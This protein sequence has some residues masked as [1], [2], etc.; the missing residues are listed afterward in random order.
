MRVLDSAKRPIA[1]FMPKPASIPN[2]P[3][4]EPER[5]SVQPK[6]PAPDLFEM[7]EKARQRYEDMLRERAAAEGNLERMRESLEAAKE[8]GEG[9][10]EFFQ[11]KIKCLVIAMRIIKG[12]EV[13]A[14]DHRFLAE[15][16]LEL[17][18]KAMSMRQ[19]NPKPEKHDRLSEDPDA[20]VEETGE[21]NAEAA[22]PIEAAVEVDAETDTG[23][24]MPSSP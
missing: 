3:Q 16:D 18:T 4:K 7:S 14:A 13:P 12:D 5:K 9:M 24:A 6:L 17:Y 10:A 11:I 1:Q 19:Q 2:I 22:A 8:M 21:N 23:G 15:N 20:G